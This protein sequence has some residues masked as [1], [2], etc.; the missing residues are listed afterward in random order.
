MTKTVEE[1]V[2]DFRLRGVSIADWSRQNNFSAS[3]VYQVLKAKRIPIRGKSHKI[4]VVLGL[5]EGF[6]ED[7]DN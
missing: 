6:L 5:K 3:L 7:P 4:A 2:E 1:V